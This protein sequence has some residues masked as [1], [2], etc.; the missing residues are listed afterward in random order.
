[1]ACLHLA[2]A[3][4]ITEACGLATG[5]LLNENTKAPIIEYGL[6]QIPD[7]PGIGMGI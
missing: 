6:I 1:M 3:N 2:A 4:E 5:A 7:I